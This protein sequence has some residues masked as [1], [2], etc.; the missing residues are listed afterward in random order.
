MSTS[1]ALKKLYTLASI[2]YFKS[3]HN[4]DFAFVILSKALSYFLQS[5]LPTT[6]FSDA[7]EADIYACLIEGVLGYSVDRNTYLVVEKK[8]QR[9]NNC[10]QRESI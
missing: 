9:K 7:L 4:F 8:L 3:S 10:S 1:L 2:K 6:S 5:Q